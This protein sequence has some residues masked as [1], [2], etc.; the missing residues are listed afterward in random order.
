MAEKVQNYA[1]HV[2]FVPLFHVVTLGILLVNA[3]YSISRVVKGPGVDTIIALL[4]A[5]ALIL[6][7][8]FAR[9]FAI[10]VQ[11]RVI[12]LEMRL[13]MR[14]LLPPDLYTRALTLTP[15]QLVALRFASDA[16][17]P[18]LCVKVL[19]GNIHDQKAIKQMVKDWQA[20]YLRA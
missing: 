7:A 20:D 18:A 9:E 1:N 3:V 13:R 16:E 6:L 12:R 15:K 10:T 2:R 14:G 8:I 17:L 5:I 19:D 11:D 4:V